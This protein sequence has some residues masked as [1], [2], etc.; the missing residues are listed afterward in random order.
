MSPSRATNAWPT[1]PKASLREKSNPSA[2]EWTPNAAAGSGGCGWSIR[3][4][5][6]DIL[7]EEGL[8]SREIGPAVP[9][10]LLD[11][12]QVIPRPEYRTT[13]ALV[14]AVVCRVKPAV[15]TEGQAEGI[16]EAPGD[17][18]DRAAV[19]R[20]PQD[21]AVARHLAAQDLALPRWRAE[22]RVGARRR[23]AA[24]QRVR[25]SK[26]TPFKVTSRHGM[27]WKSGCRSSQPKLALSSPTTAEFVAVPWP[28]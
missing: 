24:V 26:F 1:W 28:K 14:V 13:P 6:S 9:A 15:R 4:H 20:H 19:G 18:F 16:A 10:A 21:S 22:R 11:A 27:S 17:E 12:P 25:D 5:R 23:F 7:V 3:E 2:D 8:A